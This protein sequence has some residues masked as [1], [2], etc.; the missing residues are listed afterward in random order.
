MLSREYKRKIEVLNRERVGIRFDY[1][2]NSNP[3]DKKLNLFVTRAH[4]RLGACVWG[5]G[6][7]MTAVGSGLRR[8]N[9]VLV[10]ARNEI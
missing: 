10:K 8:H 3:G 1:G 7:A 2:V 5:R 4:A 9:R 6:E